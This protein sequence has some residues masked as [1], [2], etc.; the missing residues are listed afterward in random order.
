M[1][2][3][4]SLRWIGLCDPQWVANQRTLFHPSLSYQATGLNHYQPRGAVD[5]QGW[6]A[7]MEG[8]GEGEKS[9]EPKGEE[10]L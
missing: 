10:T 2:N 3:F 1:C 4:L 9:K 7:V 5:I 8:V 6:W